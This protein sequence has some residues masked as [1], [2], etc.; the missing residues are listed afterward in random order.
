MPILIIIIKKKHFC[1]CK[2]NT[3]LVI[4]YYLLSATLSHKIVD[5]E[6]MG[7]IVL[8]GEKIKSLCIITTTTSYYITITQLD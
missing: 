4:L 5:A 7:C 2:K 8:S 3:T 1:K 6:P